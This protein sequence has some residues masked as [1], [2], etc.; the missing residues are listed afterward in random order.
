MGSVRGVSDAAIVVLVQKSNQGG[1][2]APRMDPACGPR[3]LKTASQWHFVNDVRG[4]G[5]GVGGFGSGPLGSRTGW[6]PL[7][8]HSTVMMMKAHLLLT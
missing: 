7:P 4:W 8:K 1:S 3:K 5:L 2:L 6:T